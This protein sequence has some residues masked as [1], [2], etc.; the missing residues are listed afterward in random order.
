MANYDG[1]FKVA[2][3]C[4]KDRSNAVVAVRSK[5]SNFEHLEPED[6]D[7]EQGQCFLVRALRSVRGA[8][9]RRIRESRRD[10]GSV[11]AAVGH[12]L[13]CLAKQFSDP[14]TFAEVKVCEDSFIGAQRPS[15]PCPRQKYLERLA[16][17]RSAPVSVHASTSYIVFDWDDTLLCS[18]FVAR[19]PHLRPSD[20]RLKSL[21]RAAKDVLELAQQLGEAVI[22]TN[23]THRWV[24]DSAR[25][26]VPSLLPTL[27]DIPIISARELADYSQLKDMDVWKVHAFSTLYPHLIADKVVNLVS[28]GDA[29]HERNAAHSMGQERHRA[30]IKTVKLKTEPSADELVRQLTVVSASLREIVGSTTSEDWDLCLTE[31]GAMLLAV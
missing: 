12:E 31:P 30:V 22:V 26:Y 23:A 24:E 6:G 28:I 13:R 20:S 1:E 5:A 16:F 9:F 3:R 14:A 10:V 11:D 27:A 19:K 18:T 7:N 8:G 29:L 17:R 15:L 4:A 21:A 2:P 25:R